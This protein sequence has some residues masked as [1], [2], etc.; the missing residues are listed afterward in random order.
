MHATDGSICIPAADF[1]EDIGAVA[2]EIV[3][4]MSGREVSCTIEISHG[5]A[6]TVEAM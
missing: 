4:I 5:A 6:K 1:V 2:L 3:E